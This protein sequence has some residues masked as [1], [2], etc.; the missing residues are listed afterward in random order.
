VLEQARGR[1]DPGKRAA[2]VARAEKLA[3]RQ[4]PRIP[5]AQR[6]SLLLPSKSLTGAVSCFACMF[7]SWAGQL[8]GT[9]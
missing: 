3:V 8:G 4:L 6:T 5:T 2:L 1:A 9:G 7:A